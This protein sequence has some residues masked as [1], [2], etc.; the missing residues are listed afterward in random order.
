[1]IQ[2][3]FARHQY[4]D[5]IADTSYSTDN[6]GNRCSI[7]ERSLHSA[8]FYIALEQTSIFGLEIKNVRV[9]SHCKQFNQ[10]KSSTLETRA[11][12]F[13]FFPH[14]PEANFIDINIALD[15]NNYNFYFSSGFHFSD[16]C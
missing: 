11:G 1:M 5:N 12:V 14:W 9:S 8:Y 6:F 10:V 15:G 2:K 13:N 7:S 3:Y 16:G 4:V